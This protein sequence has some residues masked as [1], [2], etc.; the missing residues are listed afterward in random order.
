MVKRKEAV[1]K[2]MLRARNEDAKQRYLEVYKE[3]KRKVQRCI[4][5]R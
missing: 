2:E 5:Q 4:N 1:G 3:E